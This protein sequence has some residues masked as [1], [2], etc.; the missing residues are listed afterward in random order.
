MSCVVL[1]HSRTFSLSRTDLELKQTS[2]K[3]TDT[4]VNF[5]IQQKRKSEV[6]CFIYFNKFLEPSLSSISFLRGK[7]HLFDRLWNEYEY[8]WDVCDLV[9]FRV[10]KIL[11]EKMA[12]LVDTMNINRI[13][14]ITELWIFLKANCD[15]FYV[16]F[17]C[18]GHAEDII[19]E[20]VAPQLERNVVVVKMKKTT[21]MSLRKYFFCLRVYL[22]PIMNN[23]IL[24]FK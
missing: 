1:S 22:F 11:I 23:G 12:A 10:A 3:E 14:T 18:Q 5:N 20:D 15:V 16:F 24:W 9:F 6:Q 19:L 13:Y 4:N 17:R 7:F 2:A 21:L 8:S